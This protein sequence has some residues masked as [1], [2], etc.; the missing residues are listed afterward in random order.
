[1]PVH[2]GYP[3]VKRNFGTCKAVIIHVM[4][5]TEK[6]REKGGQKYQLWKMDRR[7]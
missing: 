2:W 3:P 1:M 7:L 6:I 5:A 4:A